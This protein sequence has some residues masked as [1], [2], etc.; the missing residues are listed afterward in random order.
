MPYAERSRSIAA[1]PD[2]VWQLV[3]FFGN[4]GYW[5]PMVDRVDCDGEHVG[6]RRT[7]YVKDGSIQVER[8]KSARPE[9]RWYCYVIE[10]SSMP[11]HNYFGELRVEDNGD[12]TSTVVWSADFEVAAATGSDFAT[13]VVEGFFKAP[14]DQLK[15]FY[16]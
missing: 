6:A 12:N 3:G 10:L 5:H 11:V 7:I 8:L 14:L 1:Q 13:I 4:I 9:E 2:A 15:H 16:G